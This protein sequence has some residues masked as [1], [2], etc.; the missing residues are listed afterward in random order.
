M[1]FTVP[2]NQVKVQCLKGI[3]IAGKKVNVEACKAFSPTT[4]CYRCQGYGHDP[5]TCKNKPKCRLCGNKHPTAFHQCY[6]CKATKECVHVKQRCSNCGGAHMAND[7][8]CPIRKSIRESKTPKTS[9][10]QTPKNQTR[11]PT[12]LLS[13]E[14]LVR[15][16]LPYKI[17]TPGPLT[18]VDSETPRPQTPTVRRV[19]IQVE[20]P[21]LLPQ[22]MDT[23]L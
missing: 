21:D 9:K 13:S 6:T 2:S 19:Q 20:T 11:N 12:N 4:Q 8:N 14:D 10:N 22:D 1:V 18:L 16:E 3:K 7:Q 15:V 5:S 17:A 23:D